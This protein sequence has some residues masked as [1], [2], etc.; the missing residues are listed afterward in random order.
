MG[1]IIIRAIT[2]RRFYS[3]IPLGIGPGNPAVDK[4]EIR[5]VPLGV[6]N[7]GELETPGSGF[8]VIATQNKQEISHFPLLGYRV[9]DREVSFLF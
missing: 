7:L 1:K 4:K 6:G 3:E 9:M 5:F 2:G 8:V